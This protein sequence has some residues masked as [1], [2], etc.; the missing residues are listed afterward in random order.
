MEMLYAHNNSNDRRKRPRRNILNQPSYS[1]SNNH[2]QSIMKFLHHRQ[3]HDKK[4]EQPPLQS[5]SM[6]L[7]KQVDA[8][9]DEFIA[10]ISV[11]QESESSTG[12]YD[13]MG[14]YSYSDKDDKLLSSTSPPLV[15]V[16]CRSRMLSW[17]SNVSVPLLDNCIMCGLASLY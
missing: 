4:V 6:S 14:R 2:H 15:N 1:L 5:P 3:C 9:Q 16:D 12:A 10:V 11:M 8:V 13:P 7:T 17:C